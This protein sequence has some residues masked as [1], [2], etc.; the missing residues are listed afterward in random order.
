M[1]GNFGVKEN[2][3]LENFQLEPDVRVTLPYDAFNN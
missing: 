2:R 3:L 1:N